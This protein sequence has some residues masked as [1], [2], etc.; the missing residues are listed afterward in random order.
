[1]VN[2]AEIAESKA[3]NVLSIDNAFEFLNEKAQPI[4][5]AKNPLGV[6]AP[7]V[8]MVRRRAK[9]LGID[10]RSGKISPDTLRARVARDFGKI[11]DLY[12]IIAGIYPPENQSRAFQLIREREYDRKL[13]ETVFSLIIESGGNFE[14]KW[15]PTAKVSQIGAA[16]SEK[17]G[18]LEKEYPYPDFAREENFKKHAGRVSAL[19]IFI[20]IWILFTGDGFIIRQIAEWIRSLINR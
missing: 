3:L 16:Y 10:L 8:W 13:I 5:T 19:G 20:I 1:M 18:S 14:N 4:A 12:I 9:S 15:Q 6:I 11:C 17:L 7:A 2:L